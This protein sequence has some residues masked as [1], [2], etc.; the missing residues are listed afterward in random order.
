[1][2]LAR[3]AGGGLVD[4]VVAWSCPCLCDEDGVGRWVGVNRES[5]EVGNSFIVALSD[6]EAE[7]QVLCEIT[8][9]LHGLRL[10]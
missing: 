6:D 8:S 9:K 3:L 4:M 1:M 2:N 5:D 7:A 10:K